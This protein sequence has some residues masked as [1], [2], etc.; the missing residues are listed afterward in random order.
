[1]LKKS[2]FIALHFYK[3]KCGTFSRLKVIG[4]GQSL[5]FLFNKVKTNQNTECLVL[6]KRPNGAIFTTLHQCL[7]VMLQFLL[8]KTIFILY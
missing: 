7:C 5:Y 2:P 6:L 3:H 4:Q 8:N 1:M